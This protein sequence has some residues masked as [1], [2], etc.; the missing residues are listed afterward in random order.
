MGG[1]LY[2]ERYTV[3]DPFFFQPSYWKRPKEGPFVGNAIWIPTTKVAAR[4]PQA[5]LAPYVVA[6]PSERLAPTGRYELDR[7]GL[8]GFAL[9]HGEEEE[10][11]DFLDRLFGGEA[12][13]VL[14]G[15]DHAFVQ[16]T[17]RDGTV[18]LVRNGFV[19][20]PAELDAL[21]EAAGASSP[22][23]REICDSWAEPQPF[24][25]PL[26]PAR[27]EDRESIPVTPFDMRTSP[28]WESYRRGRGRTAASSSRTPRPTTGRSRTTRSRAARSPS[29][30][31]RAP[32]GRCSGWPSTPRARS[33]RNAAR[34]CSPPPGTARRSH[35]SHGWSRP[36]R[37]GSRKVAPSPPA[38]PATR[39]RSA[40]RSGHRRARR[41]TAERL[42]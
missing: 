3:K 39:R 18:A 35:E 5:A 34:S 15:L 25:E 8:P 28:W 10:N 33:W 22:G 11:A 31:A 41:E 17:I 38:G 27:W 24:E 30:A 37:C 12:G 6:M 42:S 26:R 4:V 1:A 13:R 19:R 2:D 21:V 16:L 40:R 29:C 7:H 36:R 20:E 23:V 9:N 32:T 14:A